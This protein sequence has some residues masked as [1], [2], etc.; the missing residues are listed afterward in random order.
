MKIRYIIILVI[1]LVF[2]SGCSNNNSNNSSVMNETSIVSQNQTITPTTMQ[3]TQIETVVE[4]EVTV[5][6]Q[7]PPKISPPYPNKP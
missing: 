2:V 7:F 5:P 3:I 1:A 4:P 6:L